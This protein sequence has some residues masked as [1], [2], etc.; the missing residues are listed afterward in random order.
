MT[1]RIALLGSG[2]MGSAIARRLA[3]AGYE[4][5]VWD[6]TRAHAE[7]LGTGQVVETPAAAARAA[8]IVISSLTGPEA[9]RAVYEGPAGAL[10]AV[11]GQ[12][13]IDMSTVEVIESGPNLQL[14]PR[15]GDVVLFRFNV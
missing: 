12:S 9:V 3:S 6:R 4:L 13:F 14:S 11:A 1:A 15:D 5:T 10:Q 7:A 8:E 2:R